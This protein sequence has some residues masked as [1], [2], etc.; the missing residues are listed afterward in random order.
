MAGDFYYIKAISN[1]GGGGDNLAVGVTLPDGTEVNPI[2]VSAPDPDTGVDTDFCFSSA[3]MTPPPAAMRGASTCTGCSAGITF[4]RWDGVGGSSIDA[5]LTDP[6]FLD[7]GG[8][9]DEETL[10]SDAMESPVNVADNCAREMSG[11]FKPP[12]DGT[13]TFFVASDDNGTLFFGADEPT[14]TIIASVPGWTGSRQ[15]DKYPEQASPHQELV[16]G[17]YYFLRVLGN[18]GGG[19]DNLAVGVQ[20]PTGEVWGPIPVSDAAGGATYLYTSD[21]ID[22]PSPPPPGPDCSGPSRCTDQA[23]LQPM[24]D[25]VQRSCCTDPADCPNGSPTVCNAQCSAPFMS[26]YMYNA[27]PEV[28]TQFL[29]FYNVCSGNNLCRADQFVKRHQCRDCKTGQTA[30]MCAD[31]SGADTRCT[32]GGGH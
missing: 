22:A 26:M 1:D 13:Y 30:A 16:A 10:S 20:I 29:D 2:S 23:C 11:Y 24:V 15:W 17:T 19:C 3:V 14:A 7:N 27:C 28:L 9:P 32:R 21:T 5:M 6:A 18:E 8:A 25:D 31:P 4:R 12:M